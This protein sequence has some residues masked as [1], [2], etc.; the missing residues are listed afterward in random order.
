MRGDPYL[1]DKG[2][3]AQKLRDKGDLAQK[4]RDKG[5]LDYKGEGRI[6]FFANFFCF[7]CF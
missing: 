4:L 5:D 1:R 2:E 6:A 3:R 7:F